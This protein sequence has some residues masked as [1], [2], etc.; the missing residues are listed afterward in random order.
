MYTERAIISRKQ[1]GIRNEQGFMSV[2]I[3]EQIHSDLSFI[4]HTHNPISKNADEVYI[5]V[6]VG[7]GETLASANQ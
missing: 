7:L 2:L 5:E 4:I 1:F 6:A 3:Q